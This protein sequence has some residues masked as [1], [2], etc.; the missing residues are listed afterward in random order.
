MEKL[1]LE[2]PFLKAGEEAAYSSEA[3]RMA[4]ERILSILN[5]KEYHLPEEKK[6]RMGVYACTRILLSLVGESWANR[7]IGNYEARKFI[8]LLKEIK[9]ED[10]FE[11]GKM[12]RVKG[13][14]DGGFFVD[15]I[16]YMMN[17]PENEEM[18]LVNMKLSSGKVKLNRGQFMRLLAEIVRRR[19]IHTPRVKK[20]SVPEEFYKLANEIRKK[21]PKPVETRVINLRG[22]FAPCIENLMERMRSEKLPNAARWILAVYLINVGLTDEAITNIFSRS[23]DFKPRIVSYQLK[24]IRDTGYKV[25]KCTSVDS[26]GFCIPGCPLKKR[27]SPLTFSRRKE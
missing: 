13:G 17:A 16:Y 11:I 18:K 23:P 21:M 25:P 4:A 9:E 20:G 3:I 19:I 24:H 10:I 27:G 7:E 1:F 12:L 8:N 22:G 5:H 26:Y 6:V 14:M 2:F 15:A